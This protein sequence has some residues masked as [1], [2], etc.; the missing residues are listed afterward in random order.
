[1][2]IFNKLTKGF[3]VFAILLTLSCDQFDIPTFEVKYEVTS[4]ASDA[5]AKIQYQYIGIDDSGS[6]VITSANL[7]WSAVETVAVDEGNSNLLVM[8]AT[9]RTGRTVTI[10]MRIYVDGALVDDYS[11]SLANGLSHPL[12]YS[13]Y[14]Y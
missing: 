1:M 8:T 12:S 14:N 4:S 10:N 5:I 11:G 7:P 6:Y 3:F 13:I 9:N 2:K